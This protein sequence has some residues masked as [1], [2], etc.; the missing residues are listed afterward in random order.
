MTEAENQ[1]INQS[2]HIYVVLVNQTP[3]AFSL[4][5]KNYNTVQHILEQAIPAKRH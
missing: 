2:K 5:T 3:T 4:F 1:Q